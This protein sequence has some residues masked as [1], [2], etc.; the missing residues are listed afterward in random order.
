MLTI[1]LEDLLALRPSLDR[2]KAEAM[3]QGA[4]ARAGEIAPCILADDFA[5]TK[6]A[7]S[8][9]LD[10]VVRRA[11]AGSGGVTQQAAGPFSQTIDT[12]SSANLF[13]AQERLDLATLCGRRR[14]AR[15][16]FTAP[17][18]VEPDPWFGA[19]VNGPLGTAPGGR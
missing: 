9:I 1:N 19:L 18:P 16:V 2:P 3:L 8:I 15:T 7:A 11:D 17:A 4:I 10:A 5:K 13:T 12:R 6:A 14:Q